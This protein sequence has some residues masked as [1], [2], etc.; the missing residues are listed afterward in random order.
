MLTLLILLALRKIKI[1]NAGIRLRK[2]M[3]FVAF[4]CI[5]LALFFTFQPLYA[6]TQP[7]E[8]YTRHYDVR[9]NGKLRGKVYVIKKNYTDTTSMRIESDFNFPLLIPVSIKS[10]EEA[11][12]FNGIMTFSSL[13]RKVN[14]KEKVNE[15][16]LSTGE[17]YHWSGREKRD[18]PS[19][20]I[21]CSVVSLYFQEP[22]DQLAVF[23]DALGRNVPIKEI[24][25]GTYR[26]DL[27]N[28]NFNYYNYVNGICTLIEIHHSFFEIQFVLRG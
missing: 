8:Q 3:G 2:Q 5:C 1:R 7:G 20:P 18:S 19:F 9:Y 10:V 27:P 14:G 23:S 24:K 25:K 21:R 22:K 17:S 6:Q 4:Q 11:S 28:G 12:F 15:K 13:A 26:L 16:L